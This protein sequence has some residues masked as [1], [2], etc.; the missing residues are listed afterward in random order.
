ML[1]AKDSK[2]SQNNSENLPRAMML[3]ECLTV[4]QQ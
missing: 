1:L 2:Q 3:E 4:I